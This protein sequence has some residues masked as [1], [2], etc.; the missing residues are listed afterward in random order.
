MRVRPEHHPK[1]IRQHT[2][3]LA[4]AAA[5]GAAAPAQ[6]ATCTWNTTNGNWNALVNWLGCVTGNGNP[7]GVPGGADTAIIGAGSTVTV[8]TAQAINTLNNAGVVAVNDNTSLSFDARSSAA[9]FL[10]G[11]QIV[12]GG[13][14][15]R[16]YVEGGNGV[17]VA[18][19][20]TI[21][22]AGQIGQAVQQSGAS[23]FTNAG[24]ISADANGLSL[25]LLI[26]GNGGS[27]AN[28]GLMEA[29]NGGTLDLRSTVNQTGTGQIRA[30]NGSFV[31]LNGAA[32]AG[33]TVGSSGTGRVRA[34]ASFSNVLSGVTLAGVVDM[35]SGAGALRLT[36]GLTFNNGAIDVGASS[37]LYFDNRSTATQSIAGTGAINLAGGALRMEGA[38]QTTTGAN[39]TIRG[40][41][42]VGPAVVQS[43]QHTWIHNGLVSAD[44]S[45]QTLNLAKPAN[46]GQPIQNNGILEAINGG[47]LLLSADIDAASG[48]QMRAGAGS[49]IEMNGVRVTGTVNTTGTGSFLA[50]TSF[51]NVLSGVTLNGTL[52]LTGAGAQV[53]LTDGHVLNGAINVGG[54]AALYFD[55]RITAAQS[56]TGTGA[57]NLAGGVLRMEGAGQ[58][59][60]GANVTIRGHGTV[61]PAVAQTGQHTWIHNG[62]VSADVSGQ[63]LNLLPTANGSQAIQHNGTMQATGGGTLQI[64]TNVVGGAGSRYDVA[65]G[66]RILMNGVTLSGIVNQT[67]TGAIDVSSSLANALDASTLS[68]RVNLGSAGQLRVTNGMAMNGGATIAVGPGSALYFDNRTTPAQAVSGTGQIVL[69]GG[70]LRLEGGTSTTWASGITVRGNGS[71]GQA[72]L[73]S[74]N[75]TL[76][77]NG[78]IVADGGSL[79]IVPIANGGALRGT[80][81]LR[82]DGGNLTL[83]TG[84]TTNQGVLDVRATG[85]LALGNQNLV[86]SSDYTNVQAGSGNAFDR[87]AGIT[88]SGQIQAGGDVQQ[89][90]TGANISGGNTANAT[91]TIG[92]VRVG[93]TTFDY[94]VANG[95]STGPVLRG[96]VQTSVNGASITDARLSG[97]GVTASNFN[98]GGPGGAGETRSVAFTVAGAGALAP[99]NGQVINLRSNFDNIA[100]QK[101]NIVMAGGATAY[102]AAVG[103]ALTPV[104]VANQRVGGSASAVL[105]ISNTAAPGAFSEDLAASVA[106]VSGQVAASG[107]VSGR[108][109]GTSNTGSGAISVTV[110]STSAGAKTGVVN[111]DYVTTGT[112]NGVSNGLSATGVG[113]QA[114]TVNG[115]VY[116]AASG[117]LLTA[118]LNFGTLQVGQQVSQN[119]TV[120][121]TASGPAGFVEDLNVR[122]GASG[123]G[124]ISG[125]GSL[126]GILAGQNSTAANGTMTVTVTASQAGGLAS[127]IAVNYFSAGAVGGVGNGLG[128]LA[129]GSENYAVSGTI[130]AVGNVINQASPLVNNPT[131]NLGAVRTG[132][133]SPSANVSVTNV[134][135]IAPQAALN[136]S[137]SATS[138]PV[139]A[140][141]SFNLLAPGATDATSLTVG[142]LTGTAGNFTG[143]NAGK[144]TIAF[145]SD[146]ANVGNCAPNCQLALG[147][148]V[149]NIEGKVYQQ[150]VG[151]SSTPSINFGIVR[152][153]DTVSARNIVVDNSAAVAG[154]ND[155]LRAD[156]TG[157]GGAFG[158]SGSV[159]GIA[160]QA[161][162]NIAVSLSTANSGV[163]TASG[164][165]VYLSQ[166]GDMADVSAGADQTVA[167]SATVNNLAD[168]V[169]RK[170]GGAG[171]LSRVGDTFFLDY[172]TLELGDAISSD[173][174]LANLVLGPA[175]ELSGAF[176]T[177]GASGLTLAGFNPFA[178]LLAGSATGLMEIDFT[179]GAIG[180]FSRTIAFNG[181]SVNADDPAGIAQQRLLVIRG[182]VSEGGNNVPEPGSWGLVLLGGLAGGVARRRAA[183]RGAR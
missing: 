1:T 166:N 62:L 19:G 102:N 37:A 113:G 127:G 108:L 92:N 48:S 35:G 137:I 98:A 70:A 85:T 80:G 9:S 128:E 3:A 30:E 34:S 49:T 117:Q 132:A 168:G 61:G 88:G 103:S 63:T 23:V 69:S 45:G 167:I 125:S 28:S 162:G 122:F 129:V 120:R 53:R 32:I 39:I 170:V 114:V 73:Q 27:Y 52:D 147:S 164:N 175:D 14:G 38:G 182:F 13:S 16:L 67:G 119:L 99:L 183:T 160:A 136:A 91:L 133:A 68:G 86:L 43:G 2:L 144:A 174:D 107:S 90:I 100:D 6:A 139:T 75:H 22:G 165:L 26:P 156:L 131:I 151:S 179:A 66:S 83:G 161:S 74:A 58:T 176:D 33:G 97:S 93:T 145:V 24:T 12:L 57:I 82:I 143:A 155:T 51:N 20:S 21:R 46:G 10:G 138:G 173:L 163:F 124:Q 47:R 50:N 104:Q 29:R 152:V 159:A 105:S 17:S 56:I 95:G 118:P 54:T 169:F 96:A 41:G 148:Q 154:L 76:V 4:A 89:V 55:N 140:G 71:I 79:S 8:S 94:T 157:V 77:N 60:T 101:L 123:N 130:Q 78:T 36:N 106:S 7:A 81:T 25:M 181:F 65:A 18:A 158:T 40:H 121:N 64:S 11:G 84:Q 44:V 150:A 110:D 72:V 15:S 135:T 153:G 146:A 172:G 59:T 111:L 31:V 171:S 141:G 115:N 42:T 178:N 109:A 142:L 87:R 180:A 112:V 116:Q 177:S 5:L 149:V 126:S 134:A